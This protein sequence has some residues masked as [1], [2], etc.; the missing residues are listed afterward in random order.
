MVRPKTA[1][2]RLILKQFQHVIEGL[3]NNLGLKSVLTWK[4]KEVN[5][6]ILGKAGTK[7]LRSFGWTSNTTG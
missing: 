7:I 5:K 2:K 6:A 4:T 3:M 1:V